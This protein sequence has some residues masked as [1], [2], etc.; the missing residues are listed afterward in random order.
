MEKKRELYMKVTKLFTLLVGS[1]LL[2]SAST[3]A[4]NGNKKSLHLY[5]SVTLDGKQLPAGDYRFEWTGTGPEV[6]LNV[7]KGKETVA[8]VSAHIVPVSTPFRQDGYT[9]SVGKDGTAS[10]S[11]FF[12]SGDKFDLEIGEASSA[13]T[14]PAATT[15]GSN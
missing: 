3:F 12:F 5:E 6:Q 8:T 9:A 4:G 10:V 11:Q 7:L 1:S 2:L 13:K 14:A 15:T